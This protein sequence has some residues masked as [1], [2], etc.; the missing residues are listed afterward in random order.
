MLGP[1]W[2]RRSGIEASARSGSWI[3]RTPCRRRVR[4]GEVREV[5][6][7]FPSRP[8]TIE[9]RRHL[10]RFDWSS[11]RS[12]ASRG[13]PPSGH[14]SR[15]NWRWD[16]EPFTQ[17]SRRT[18]CAGCNRFSRPGLATQARVNVCTY[19]ERFGGFAQTR[20]LGLIAGVPRQGCSPS[21]SSRTGS[22][23]RRTA[24][25]RIPPHTGR[26]PTDWTLH[27]QDR[28]ERFQGSELRPV[29]LPKMDLIQSKRQELGGGG[30]G[31]RQVPRIRVRLLAPP[32][33]ATNKI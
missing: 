13:G 19:L 3:A 8:S 33:E 15:K 31:G 29:G 5:R 4:Q 12:A 10:P 11:R 18:C 17:Q 23:G 22:D 21:G 30:V 25:H 27:K 6:S 1:P 28:L 20:E 7:A 9:S 2:T 16:L 26:G 24:G 14:G 32:P